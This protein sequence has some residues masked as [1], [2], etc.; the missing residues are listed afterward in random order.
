MSEADQHPADGT[1][2]AATSVQQSWRLRIPSFPSFAFCFWTN[3]LVVLFYITWNIVD[4]QYH[5][6]LYAVRC[7]IG[8][9]RNAAFDSMWILV[10]SWGSLGPRILLF[11][12]LVVIAVA[13]SLAMILRLV[14]RATV[15]RMLMLV[16]VICTWLSLFVSYRPIHEWAVLRRARI[17]LP[18][19]EAA[20]HVLSRHWPTK[21]GVLPGAGAFYAYPEDHPDI[22]LLHGNPRYPVRES[23]GYRIERSDDGTIR[24]SLYGAIDRQVEFHPGGSRPASYKSS[25]G[26][27]MTLQEAVRLDGNHWYLV[28][29]GES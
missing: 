6:T 13:S 3:V 16:L 28:R 20:A 19:F 7:H 26:D 18:R 29:Y 4:A 10:S 27:D 17:A 21:D 22:L 15:R 12:I 25:L 11:A 2:I 8:L 5:M 23:F 24:F 9:K 14:P 1:S